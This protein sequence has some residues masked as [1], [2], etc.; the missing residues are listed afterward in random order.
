MEKVTNDLW[1][2]ADTLLSDMDSLFAL[3]RKVIQDRT[4]RIGTI[5]DEVSMNSSTSEIGI[6]QREQGEL[7]EQM[8]TMAEGLCMNVADKL[9]VAET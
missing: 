2:A 6:Q 8:T 1:T 5:V 7:K 3:T 4:R 9:Q